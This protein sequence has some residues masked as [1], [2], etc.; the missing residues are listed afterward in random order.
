MPSEAFAKLTQQKQDQILSCA[1]RHFIA[2]GYVG[3]ST[4]R[5]VADIGISKGSLFYYF[6]GKEDLYLTV[7]SRAQRAIASELR[8]A[9]VE[10]PDDLIRRLE[11][12][13]TAGGEVLKQHPE[14][15][16]L[17]EGFLDSGQSQLLQRFMAEYV[18][19]QADLSLSGWFDGVDTTGFADEPEV[20]YEVVQWMFTGIK[21]EYMSARASAET[22]LE[23]TVDEITSRM[24]RA[25]RVL[26]RAIY[27]KKD[28]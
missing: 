8:T 18:D 13:L 28:E 11:V 27:Q 24:R 4:N 10:W 14:D 23:Q 2:Q 3:A 12:I 15:Y 9:I 16:R 7:L 1:R 17:F 25:M 19:G 21:L 6:D 5:I 20:I 26:R 22:T